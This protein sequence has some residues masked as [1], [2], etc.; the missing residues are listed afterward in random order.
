MAVHN[1]AAEENVP[2]AELGRLVE[3]MKPASS[4]R[5]R[6]IIIVIV[7]EGIQSGT[8]QLHQAPYE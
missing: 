7:K 6:F 2:Q 1:R 5:R 4:T 8:L 3:A